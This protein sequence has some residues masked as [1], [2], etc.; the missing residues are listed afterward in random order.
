M[1]RNIIKKKCKL[2]KSI[3]PSFTPEIYSLS[4][5]T[6]LSGAYSNV[7]INGK[8]FLPNGVTT[9]NFGTYKNIPVTYSSSFVISFVVPTSLP[10]G[11]YNVVVSNNYSSNFSPNINNFYNQNTNTSNSMMY[12]L[13]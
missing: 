9:V 11:N 5:Y 6:S 4:V 13:T 3:L 1:I 12:T 7:F 8:N 10:A 2:T